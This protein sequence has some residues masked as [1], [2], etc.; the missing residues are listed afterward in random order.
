MTDLRRCAGK[1]R[2]GAPCTATANLPQTHC[3]W[4]DPANAAARSQNASKAA[5]SKNQEG[6]L[7]ET[8][9]LLRGI[10]AKVLKDEIDRGTASVAAQVLGVYLRAVE[11][12]RKVLETE[13]LE[14]ELAELKAFVDQNQSQGG[15]RWGR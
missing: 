3:W 7:A 4:H 11:I 6:E 15:R 12:E 13:K 5:R 9:R 2:D 10:A 1:R 8:K 14:V